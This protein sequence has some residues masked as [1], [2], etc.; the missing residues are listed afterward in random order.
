MKT[1]TQ[2]VDSIFVVKINRIFN[3]GDCVVVVDP[4]SPGLGWLYSFAGTIHKLTFSDDGCHFA[5]VVDGDD[6]YY[7]IDLEFIQVEEL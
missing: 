5:T 3:V 7:D 6:N 2:L 4:P 1:Q